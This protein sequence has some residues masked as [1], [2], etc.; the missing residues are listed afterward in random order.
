MLTTVEVSSHAI[1]LVRVDN[2]RITDIESYPIPKDSDPIQTLEN[3]PLPS[4][5]G[6]VRVVIAHDDMLLRTMLQP[7]SPPERLDRMV[8]FELQSNNDE[9]TTVGWH[10]VNAGGPDDM[11][12]LTMTTKQKLI[13]QVKAALAKHGGKVISLT[14]PAI[15]LYESYCAASI[16]QTGH[17]IMADVGGENV[18]IAIVV[19]GELIFIRN[20]TPGMNELVKQVAE[21]RTLSPGDASELVA[22]LGN[23]A[24]SDLHD[25]IKKQVGQVA[26]MLTAN[27]RFAKAQLKI[28]SLDPKVIYL[29]GAGAQVHGFIS[30]LSERMGLP[31]HPLNPFAG[32][33]INASTERL[34]RYAGLPSSWA[35]SLGVARAKEVALDALADE[36]AQR[37]IFWRTAGALRIAAAAMVVLFV[38]AL[39]R[40]EINIAAANSSIK[41]LEGENN[42]GL[43]PVAKKKRKNLDEISNTKDLDTS[44]LAWIDGERRPGRVAL[45]LLSAIA[46]E[47]NPTSA[48]VFLQS[49]KVARKPG[50]VIVEIQGHAEGSGKLATDAVLHNF[51]EGLIKRYPPIVSIKQLPK[52]IDSTRQQFHYELTISDQPAEVTASKG[53][54]LS[55]SVVVPTNVDIDGAARVAA[56]RV[57]ENQ[58]SINVSI[59]A[60]KNQAQE[61]IINFKN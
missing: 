19:D 4:P 3:A 30:A 8:H 9:P 20:Q 39:V 44:R 35:V 48:P 43:V 52:P 49:Y 36:R 40:Q 37:V 23:G 46:L 45:E 54:N 55:L 25:M 5:L 16:N 1:R 7:P 27:I 28:D 15:G 12:L 57:R 2:Q 21:I 51:E 11:R 24:P 41:D 33:V 13:K 18:H 31:V 42:E 14:H 17:A 29:T 10:L 26:N 53:P 22:K 59:R 6:K 32:T 38:L 34:D 61:K 56:L 50:L 47:S 58:P 60:G